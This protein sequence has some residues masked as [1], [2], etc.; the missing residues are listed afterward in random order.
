MDENSKRVHHRSIPINTSR[1]IGDRMRPALDLLLDEKIT[2]AELAEKMDMNRASVNRW[3]QIDDTKLSSLEEMGKVLGY[4][5]EW[6]F[7]KD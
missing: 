1:T 4:H 7:V 2:I 3:F 6:K 5:V